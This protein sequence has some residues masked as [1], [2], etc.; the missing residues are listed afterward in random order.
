MIGLDKRNLRSKNKK[1][2]IACSGKRCSNSTWQGGGTILGWFSMTRSG[3]LATF[4]LESFGKVHCVFLMLSYCF[5]VKR[6]PQVIEIS[7]LFLNEGGLKIVT[8]AYPRNFDGH[9]QRLKVNEYAL[10]KHNF[11]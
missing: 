8:L 10:R 5:K 11:L 4:M 3:C 1:V 6:L 2:K 9:F 7:K